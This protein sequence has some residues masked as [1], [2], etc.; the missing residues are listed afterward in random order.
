M[1]TQPWPLVGRAEELRVVEDVTRGGDGPVGVVLAGAAGV[2]KTRLA[3]EALAL[4]ERRGAVVHR[5]TATASSRNVPLGAFPTVSGT[6][7]S[8]PMWLLRRAREA[9]LAR[10]DDGAVVIGVDDAHLLDELSATVVHQV[11]VRR[12][13]RVVLTVRSGEPAPDAV[14]G[15]WKDGHLRRLEL[16]PLT[17]EVT[18][19]LLEEV[20]GGPV[21]SGT[22]RALWTITRGNA[23]YL[24]QLVDGE[25]G[26]GR[27]ARAPGVWRWSGRPQLSPGLTELLHDRIGKL[28]DAQRDVVDMLALGEP[29]GVPVLARL[30]GIAAVERAEAR[31]VVEVYPDGR[32]M[33]ARLSHPLFG[34]LLRSRCGV[35]RAR[36]LRGRIATA[37]AD[38][39]GRRS[40]DTLRRA[41]LM[42]DSDL[43]HDAALLVR[44]AEHA[45][46]LG[47]AGLSERLARAGLAAGG[48][49]PARFALCDAMLGAPPL[50]RVAAELS[51]LATLV[52]TD[53]E[54][55]RVATHRAVTLFWVLARPDE[56][57]GVV[58]SALAEVTDLGCRQVLTG[59]QSVL[60]GILCRPERAMAAAAAVLDDAQRAPVAASIYACW[61]LAMGCGALGRLAGLAD[62]VRRVDAGPDRFEAVHYR[63]AGIANAWT[64][65][66]RLAGLLAEAEENTEAYLQRYQDAGGRSAPIS[67]VLHGLVLLDRGRVRAAARVL[68]EAGAELRGMHPVWSYVS[69]VGLTLAL[70]MAGEATGARQALAAA[71]TQRRHPALVFREPDWLLARAWV[72]AAEG[73]VAEA[74]ALA[75]AAATLAA[76][77][78]QPAVEVVARHTAVCFGDREQAARLAEL[79]REV[80]GPRAPAAAAHSAA[81]AATDGDGLRTAAAQLADMGATLLAADAAAQAAAAYA[82]HGRKG[83]A[84]TA[85]AQAHR[86]ARL[87]GGAGTPALA[88]AEAPAALTGREREIVTLAARGLS[89]RAIAER[90]VISVRT[91]ENHLYRASAKLGATDRSEL[92]TVLHG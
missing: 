32:R 68:R 92:A 82:R 55:T 40:D 17:V 20:L 60:D 25:L 34:E 58:A 14:T 48:G 50:D 41:T 4:A 71:Q 65:A 59:L 51:T 74:R 45:V 81:L 80:D 46:R 64:R 38:S 21:A 27:L 47:D 75:G 1:S 28:S 5:A 61:G 84:L 30:A 39:G 83:S 6:V 87:C 70:G 29:L 37:L 44:A 33:Q 11:A 52:R 91:V 78:T 66:L 8:D 12:E 10:A 16:A 85:A 35:V 24:R 57:E 56:A 89:N 86:L 72:A 18:G 26:A 15:L 49:I 2:G 54:R 77:Q 22:T 90:L 23:L 31:G 73:A 19:E 42:L 7:G 63:V 9:L 43:D 13:A 88:A 69:A 62:A 36:R 3:R 67:R 79:S 53:H 76:A